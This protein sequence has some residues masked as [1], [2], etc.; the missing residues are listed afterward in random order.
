[1]LE[2]DVLDAKLVAARIRREKREAAAAADNQLRTDVQDL[3]RGLELLGDA[4]VDQ[5]ETIRALRG[6]VKNL[7][8]HIATLSAPR[9]VHIPQPR[10]RRDG[11]DAELER[12]LYN[13]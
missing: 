9:A 8:N 1:M 2:L 12:G 5:A 3:K 4:V 6:E 11:L 10:R 7:R 13:D